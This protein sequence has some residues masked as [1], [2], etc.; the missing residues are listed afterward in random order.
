[1]KGMKSMFG[2]SNHS[3]NYISKYKPSDRVNLPVVF[4]DG[5]IDLYHLTNMTNQLIISYGEK[6]AAP[7][8]VLEALDHLMEQCVD[9]FIE[10]HSAGQ[11][12][13]TKYWVEF[14]D[15]FSN[16]M[17]NKGEMGI[18]IYSNGLPQ[19]GYRFASLDAYFQTVLVGI[20][21]KIRELGDWG[22]FIETRQLFLQHY[23]DYSLN[24][25]KNVSFNEK[26]KT[27]QES[28]RVN[29]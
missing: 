22:D 5:Y 15:N 19:N 14:V 8:V 16:I 10:K 3:Q 24:T 11:I 13:Q 23:L 17:I 12:S 18:V 26:I 6:K 1:M 20:F 27:I 7:D 25:P 28:F 29:E 4:K 9:F 2:N 21:I